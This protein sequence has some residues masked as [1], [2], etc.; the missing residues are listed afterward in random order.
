M[1]LS[2]RLVF[3]L[4]RRH[5]LRRRNTQSFAPLSP[6]GVKGGRRISTGVLE[7]NR[8]QVF[9]PRR[10]IATESVL[11]EEEEHEGSSS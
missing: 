8:H 5:S 2:C 9:F 11:E 3:C 10:N 6:P 4:I 7:G 1:F